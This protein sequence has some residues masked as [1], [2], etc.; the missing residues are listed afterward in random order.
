MRAW[1]ETEAALRR[2]AERRAEDH[3]ETLAELEEEGIDLDPPAPGRHRH[4]DLEHDE[5]PRAPARALG[6]RRAPGHRDRR[7]RR[8]GP[9]PGR[10][11]APRGLAGGRRR[12]AGPG[13]AGAVPR[14]RP[15][16]PR[17][18]RGRT[19]LLDDVE[20]VILAVPDDVVAVARRVPAPVRRPGDGPHERPAGRRGAR[21]RRWRPGPRPARSTRW[22]RSPTWTGRSRRSTGRRSRS[23]A[24]TSWPRTCSRHGG[25]DRR[26]AGPP[27]ARLQGGLPRGGRPRGRRRRR[28][29]GHDPRGGARSWAWTRR[30]RSRSTCRSW[31]RPSPTRGRSGSRPRSPVRPPAATP[32]RCGAHL[33]AL[34][35]ERPGRAARVPGPGRRGRCASPIERGALSPEAAERLRT[36]LAGTP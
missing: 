31:S 3:E 6:A 28:A 27:G 30:A 4:G 16:R 2:A 11:A 36:A 12:V 15:G 5:R 8:R 34:G 32:A 14:A 19:A 10:R 22:S 18:R 23:R 25:G 20:L 17:V 26:R 35:R 9:G 7:R 13:P 1:D 29:P 21:G 24:T 33:D